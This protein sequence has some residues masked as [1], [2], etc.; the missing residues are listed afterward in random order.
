MADHAQEAFLAFE[1]RGIEGAA[2]EI[3]DEPLPAAL[4]GGPARRERGRDRFLNRLDA[5]E[6]REARGLAGCLDLR[7]LEQSGHGDH[8][9][10]R[11]DAELGFDIGLERREHES[12]E[13]LGR[14][15]E[16]GGA[17]GVAMARTHQAFE[18]AARVFGILL[19]ETI[20]SR[21]DGD[22]PARV[23]ADDA[24]GEGLAGARSDWNHLLAVEHASSRV[25][26]PEVDSQI[27]RPVHPESKVTGSGPP[28]EIES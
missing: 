6:P 3:V 13:L 25:R 27:E 11:T 4:V 10:F 9:A 28:A 24:G 2:S 18:F 17:E 19:Q 15:F 14:F 16:L 12:S 26:R 21:A 20:R 1:Q 23:D 8:R 7:E 22:V 5:R